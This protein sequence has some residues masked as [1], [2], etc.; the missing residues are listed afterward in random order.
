MVG[1]LIAIAGNSIFFKLHNSYSQETFFEGHQF[2]KAVL[3][4]KN[5][6][7]GIIGRTIFGFHFL[8]FFISENA[9]R[10]KEA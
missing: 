5:W 8:I 4:F 9:F 2:S 3:L 7:F 6:L 10:D 1:L